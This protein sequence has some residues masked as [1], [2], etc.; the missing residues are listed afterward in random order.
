MVGNRE[1]LLPV[2]I[3]IAHHHPI[4]IIIVK[5]YRRGKANWVACRRCRYSQLEPPGCGLASSTESRHSYPVSSRRMRVRY[6]HYTRR[7]IAFQRTLK[8]GRAGNV[9]P[10]AG[11]RRRIGR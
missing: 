10:S 11:G 4:R 1:V 3:K 8:V 7:R 2:A 9:D 5:V 6:P